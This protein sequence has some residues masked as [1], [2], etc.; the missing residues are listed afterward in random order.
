[1]NN[2]HPIFQQ[3]LDAICPPAKERE[4]VES[5]DCWCNPTLDY[6]DDETGNRPLRSSRAEL[7]CNE[8]VQMPISGRVYDI[9]RCV[10]HIVAALNAGG[11]RTVASCC[12]PGKQH[13]N[14]ALEDGRELLVVRDFATARQVE[15]FKFCRY[16]QTNG[17]TEDDCPD[18][19]RG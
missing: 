7:M 17:H 3:I 15:S 9:D 18:R 11:V 2:T 6:V 8:V 14:I 12:G 10:S 1:M 4:H 13:G 5:A 19:H 16:C